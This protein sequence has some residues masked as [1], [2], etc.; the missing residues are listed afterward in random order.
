MSNA[1]ARGGETQR[2]A[3][4]RAAANRVSAAAR[5]VLCARRK[6]C[7]SNGGNNLSRAIND[8]TCNRGGGATID[9]IVGGVGASALAAQYSLKYRARSAHGDVVRVFRG[10]LA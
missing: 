10:G 6:R 2:I 7:C 4:Y 3:R 9:Q 1:V 5:C 8:R